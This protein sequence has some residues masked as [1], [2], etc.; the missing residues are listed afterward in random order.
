MNNEK[1]SK[2]WKKLYQN[3]QELTKPTSIDNILSDDDVTFLKQELK[4]IINRFLDK[5]ELHKGIKVY[6]N[7]ELQNG[8]AEEMAA[9]R[10]EENETI[11]QWCMKLF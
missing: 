11:E 1:N 3:S 9:N 10:P 5:G 2:T 8:I 4:N 7:H 6:I